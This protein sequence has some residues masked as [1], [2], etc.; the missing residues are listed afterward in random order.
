MKKNIVGFV[1]VV[2][3]VLVLVG[4]LLMQPATEPVEWDGTI[5]IGPAETPTPIVLMFGTQDPD[6]Y[7]S[8]WSYM[9][10]PPL[11]EMRD[12]VA[13]AEDNFSDVELEVV[14]DPP[15]LLSA[16]ESIPTPELTEEDIEIV[17]DFFDILLSVSAEDFCQ[18]L[19]EED[20]PDNNFSEIACALGL[21]ASESGKMI[22][23]TF[24]VEMPQIVQ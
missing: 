24:G 11:M 22:F 17:N 12:I 21:S 1:L 9:E 23:E 10:L 8:G 14:L 20:E 18:Q 5:S 15:A 7:I 16:P 19:V 2:L 4:M 3:F 13:T 6:G